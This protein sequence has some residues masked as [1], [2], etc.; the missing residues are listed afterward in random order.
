M[1][2]R[3]WTVQCG[4]MS[5]AG[6]PYPAMKRAHS[7]FCA[8]LFFASPFKEARQARGQQSFLLGGEAHR[9]HAGPNNQTGRNA[10]VYKAGPILFGSPAG[11][12]FSC[13]KQTCPFG[14]PATVWRGMGG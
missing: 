1:Y 4:V 10:D 5:E 14:L 6:R 11:P 2:F 7:L 8:S 9:K 13:L 12:E 3:L